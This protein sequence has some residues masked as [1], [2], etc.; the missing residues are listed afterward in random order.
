MSFIV[1]CTNDWKLSLMAAQLS[2]A[3]QKLNVEQKLSGQYRAER[4]QYEKDL[5]HT[6][7]E[8]GEVREELHVGEVREELAD[9]RKEH[10]T[11]KTFCIAPRHNVTLLQK[12]LG[13]G[14][15]GS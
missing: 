10:S 7:E 5:G 1:H 2:E 12:P 3:Q 6:R 15:W 11:C 14:A 4:D 9:L 8:L 13:G